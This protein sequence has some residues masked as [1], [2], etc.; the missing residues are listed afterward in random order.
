MHGL[1]PD[2]ARV[3]RQRHGRGSDIAAAYRRF[4]REVTTALRQGISKARRLFDL[5]PNLD[6]PLPLHIGKHFLED[7]PRKRKAFDQAG[8]RQHAAG[9]KVFCKQFRDEARAQSGVLQ[10][11]RL[12]RERG[13]RLEVARAAVSIDPECCYVIIIGGHSLASLSQSD[14]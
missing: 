14:A 2:D 9:L 7:W 5:R 8:Q 10:A 11:A 6:K 1:G 13:Q 12:W 4:Q 3:V